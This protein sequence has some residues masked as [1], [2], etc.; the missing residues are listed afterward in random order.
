M[1]IATPYDF[2]TPR[3]RRG[4]DSAKWT[5]FDEDILPLWVAEM[6]FQAPPPV[7]EAIQQRLN[8]GIFGYTQVPD[9][10]RE[11]IV[12][13]MAQRYEWAIEPDWLLFNPGMVVTLNLVAQTVGRPGDGIVMDTPVYGPFL[14]VP[15]NRQRFAHGIELVR[16]E[17]DA[18]TFHYE[19][20]FERFERSLSPQDSLYYLCNPHNPAGK[21]YTRAEQER[22]AEICARHDIIICSDEIHSDLLM[23]DA[24]HVPMASLDPEIAKRTITLIAPTK[25][26]NIPGMACSISIIPDDD[27]R[28]KMM[29]IAWNSGYHVDTLAYHAALGAYRDGDEWLRACLDYLTANRDFAVNFIRE[30]IPELQTTVPDATFLM[31]LDC[32]ALGHEGHLQAWFRDQAKVALSPGDFF[33][34]SESQYVRLNFATTRSTLQEAL[35]RIR[36]AVKNR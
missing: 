27:L 3:E 34:A 6:D 13:R 25:T 2:D 35:E 17:D 21:T 9:G 30:E 16:V 19:V 14:R 36:D 18:Q 11:V 23:G 26:F 22:L 8:H 1:T 5:Y 31:W 7:L 4:S 10:L 20:D 28:A 15:G 24:E 32:S 33:G 12:E 29:G